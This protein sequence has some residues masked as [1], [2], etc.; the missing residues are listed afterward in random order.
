MQIH[1][2]LLPLWLLGALRPAHG[3]PGDKIRPPL[4]GGRAR[5]EA[6]VAWMRREPPSPR[7]PVRCPPPRRRGWCGRRASST[8]RRGGVRSSTRAPHRRLHRGEPPRRG[9]AGQQ[10]RRPG[11][12]QGERHH[13]R[14]LLPAQPARDSAGG[15]GRVV[16][17]RGHGRAEQ[18]EPQHRLCLRSRHREGWLRW[19]TAAGAMVVAC[20]QAGDGHRGH[21]RAAVR[22]VCLFLLAINCTSNIYLQVLIRACSVI[23]TGDACWRGLAT[24]IHK[25]AD[26]VS[27]TL[28]PKVER[29]TPVAV[30][31]PENKWD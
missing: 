18:A 23:S 9:A 20:L 30:I 17:R 11:G 28:V 21:V 1:C 3:F 19:C 24:D 6:R 10:R 14:P 27:V 2:R 13:H 15:G 12:H 4:P 25:L 8:R 31:L 29:Y 22:R 5:S 26:A 7:D 16:R